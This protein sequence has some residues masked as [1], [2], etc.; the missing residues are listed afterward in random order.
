MSAAGLAFRFRVFLFILLYLLGF[1]PPWDFFGGSR[2]TLWLA[3]SAW[4][5]RVGGIGL[6]AA[7]LGVTL[8]AL[9][10]FVAGA[11]LR[12]WGTAYLGS[13]VMRGAALAGGRLVAA[14]PY[15][16][17]RNPLYLGSWLLAIGVSIL[18]PPSGALF[19]LPAFT[20]YSLL[21]IGVEER[22]LTQR[23]RDVYLE[24]CRRVP[25]LLPRVSAGD[26]TSSGNPQW[27]SAFL[28]ETY[29]VAITLCFAVFAWRYNARILMRCVLICYGLSL[30]V[31]AMTKPP[32]A[33]AN[34]L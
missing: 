14:G 16:Y 15:R 3:A 29:P 5:A 33:D 8:A 17:V 2:G 31:R 12:V 1:F 25:R 4:V 23:Q 19:F 7:G 18:M 20:I 24:Y 30:V 22:F 13:G 28:N 10:C 32:L 34:R 27:M 6:A 26:V 21:L 9:L 11:I